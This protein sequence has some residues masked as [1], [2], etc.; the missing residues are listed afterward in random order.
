MATAAHNNM[1]GGGPSYDPGMMNAGSFQQT[2]SYSP[3]AASGVYRLAASKP[4]DVT[5]RDVQLTLICSEPDR[6]APESRVLE[7][8][9]DGSPWHNRGARFRPTQQIIKIFL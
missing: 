5:V 8:S 4:L 6:F 2:R 1:I 9:K 3:A 7:T